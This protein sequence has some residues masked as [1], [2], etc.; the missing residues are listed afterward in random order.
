MC[1]PAPFWTY[2][3]N[4]GEERVPK[5]YP[6][7]LDLRE[8]PVIMVGGDRVAA[9][10]VAALVASGARVSAHSPEF[11]E[12]LLALAEQERVT[13]IYKSYEPGDLAGAFVVVAVPGD[14]QQIEAIWRETRE[15]GQPVNI[16]DVPRYCSFILPSVLRR[17]QLTVAVS[18]EGASPAL[19]KRIRQQLEDVFPQAYGAYIDLAAL[20]RTYL[21]QRGVSYATRDTFFQDFMNSPILT[22]LGAGEIT[23][24][25]DLTAELLHTY[26][27]EVA[28]SELAHAFRE[29]QGY[30]TSGV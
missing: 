11:C 28:V 30:A 5:Y 18:T 22:L 24:A 4:E 29:E 27:V 13:L 17:G 3:A 16:V 20:A 19:A 21:R 6:V 8:R 7:M 9:E 10:K 2:A 25:L 12:E 14:E 23:R 1:S 26:G 15:R